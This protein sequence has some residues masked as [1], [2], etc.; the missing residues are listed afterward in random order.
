[1]SVHCFAD[2]HHQ[3]PRAFHVVLALDQCYQPY[4]GGVA[5]QVGVNGPL[6][7]VTPVAHL[8]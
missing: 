8:Q 4:W 7:Q 5:R 6:T 2:D 1:M 3:T